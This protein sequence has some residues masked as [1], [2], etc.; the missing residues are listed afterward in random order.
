MRNCCICGEEIYFGFNYLCPTCWKIWKHE[1]ASPWLKSL[2]AFEQKDRFYHKNYD[3]ILV[4]LEE[5]ENN[6]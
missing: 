3:N 6:E 1:I 2:M 5:M 4:P